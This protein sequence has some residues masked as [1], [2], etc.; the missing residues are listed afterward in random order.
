MHPKGEM[1]IAKAERGADST[2]QYVCFGG[3]GGKT[4]REIQKSVLFPQQFSP[5]CNDISA[6]AIQTR[7]KVA[8]ISHVPV[9][10]MNLDMSPDKRY[11]GFLVIFFN[12]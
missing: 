6:I 3:G 11:G 8:Y 5:I 9:V 10:T 1:S 4:S 2:N 7:N 12:C